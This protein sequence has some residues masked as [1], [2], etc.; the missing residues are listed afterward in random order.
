MLGEEEAKDLWI[1]VN[2]K[3]FE[4]EIPMETLNEEI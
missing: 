3:I 1:H 2:C 4:T